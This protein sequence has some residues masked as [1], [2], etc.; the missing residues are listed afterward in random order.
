VLAACFSKQI[1][2]GRLS[3]DDTRQMAQHFESLVIGS[4]IRWIEL[5]FDSTP[6]SVHSGS[7]SRLRFERL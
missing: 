3:K 4:P 7:I 2:K 5:G 1:E 6:L